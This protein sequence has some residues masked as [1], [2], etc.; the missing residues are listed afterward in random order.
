MYYI[1]DSHALLLLFYGNLI[2]P[3]FIHSFI[4]SIHLMLNGQRSLI[5]D[6]I[7]LLCPTF[8]CVIWDQVWHVGMMK[9]CE[10]NHPGSHCLCLYETWNRFNIFCL[11]Y[12]TF[13]SKSSNI[14]QTLCSKHIELSTKWWTT[15]NLLTLNNYF[16]IF[17]NCLT[18]HFFLWQV[19]VHYLQCSLHVH[20]ALN[21][22]KDH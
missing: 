16:A 15:D 7:L 13:L 6:N 9:S 21:F 12:L 14:D 8:L 10:K 19:F 22:K 1:S 17:Q 20:C 2:V 18:S 5:Y 11:T 3:W 4:P